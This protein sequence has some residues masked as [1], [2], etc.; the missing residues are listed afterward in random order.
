MTRPIRVLHL[1]DNSRDAEII[2]DQLEV[3]GVAC[4][5]SLVR[6]KDSFEAALAGRII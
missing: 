6:N 5:I 2:H 3:D 1:E 4:Q